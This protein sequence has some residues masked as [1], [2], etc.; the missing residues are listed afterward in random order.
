MKQIHEWHEREVKYN[1]KHFVLHF[2]EDEK[3]INTA[4]LRKP[5]LFPEIQEQWTLGLLTHEQLAKWIAQIQT[6]PQ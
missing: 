5:Q 1:V 2:Y 3:R 4:K 6:F